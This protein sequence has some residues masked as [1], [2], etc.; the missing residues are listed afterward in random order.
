MKWLL[1]ICLFCV[2]RDLCLDLRHLFAELGDKECGNGKEDHKRHGNKAVKHLYHSNSAFGLCND[3]V[4]L[5]GNISCG[6]EGKSEQPSAK[7]LTELSTKAIKECSD[8][9]VHSGQAEVLVVCIGAFDFNTQ[10]VHIFWDSDVAKWMEGAAYILAKH[11]DA[12]LEQKVESLI[13]RIEKYQGDDG[14]FN[15]Y[16]T[17]R[18]PQGRFTKRDNHVISFSGILRVPRISSSTSIILLL[19]SGARKR[20]T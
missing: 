7:A 5:G 8:G 1:S 19:P 17:M 18:E 9:S 20:I 16:Y 2:S 13:D 6:G 12:L 15:I 4:T 10:K 11:P 3:G 14:Y